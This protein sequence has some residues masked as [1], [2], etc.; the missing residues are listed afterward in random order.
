[1]KILVCVKQV[2]DAETQI[3]I[4]AGG[5]CLLIGENDWRMNRFDE[6]AVE[7]TLRIR[8]SVSGSVVEAVSIGPA[9]TVAVLCRALA[10]GAD[11]A[12]HILREEEENPLPGD[13]AAWIAACIHGRGYDLILT[14]VMSE[15]VMHAQT[16]PILAGMRG[17]QCIVAINRDPRAAIFQAADVAVVEELVSFLPLLID[18]CRKQRGYGKEAGS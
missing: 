9:R 12:L 14:G 1:V 17:S 15:D 7:E 11:E 2:P 6:F 3:R 18:A 5:R 4:A 10:M 8:E 16:G 13:V